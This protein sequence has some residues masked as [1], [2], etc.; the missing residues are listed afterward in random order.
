MNAALFIAG[1]VVA[2][3]GLTMLL[4]VLAGGHK[5]AALEEANGIDPEPPTGPI[6]AWCHPGRDHPTGH[7]ICARH[8]AEQLAKLDQP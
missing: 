3:G 7:T 2:F 6:C 1:G 8:R 4:C 5:G